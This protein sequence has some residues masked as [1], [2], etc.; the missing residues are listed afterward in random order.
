[1]NPLRVGLVVNPVAGIGGS[2]GL[3]G[4][5][6]EDVQ[7]WA[8]SLGGIPAAPRRATEALEVLR[9]EGVPFTLVTGGGPMGEDVA[10]ASGRAPVEVAVPRRPHTDSTS[11]KDTTQLVAR[12]ASDGV[13]VLLFAGGDGTARD[14]AAA[15]ASS[16][17]KIPFPAI[18]IPGGVKMHS[19]VF[20]RSP[21]A[22]GWMAAEVL[23][24]LHDGL[25]VPLDLAEIVDLDE[26]D[27]RAG[28]MTPRM[29]G[30]MPVP[31]SKTLMQGR[32]VGAGSS[33]RS[34]RAAGFAAEVAALMEE[35]GGMWVMGPGTTVA[36]VAS[37]LGVDNTLLGF[38][39]VI[40]GS[41]EALD[42]NA[43]QLN[44]MAQ[45]QTTHVVLSPVGG[46]GMLLGRGNQQLDQRF[47]ES[48]AARQLVI[49]ATEDKLARLEASSLFLD[50]PTHELNQKLSGYHRVITGRGRFAI[51]RVVAPRG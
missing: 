31:R 10:V 44:R 26:A 36:S 35:R 34:P 27:R 50:A 47:L 38:D 45:R 4:S 12:L 39:V 13:D 40:A 25:P 8:R 43:E 22:A 48:L 21:R 28:I 17:R 30:T 24:R 42:V 23:A 14:V 49:V 51:I 2:V 41:T 16:S 15:L 1:M 33:G 37:T 29:F 11:V 20:A 9:R 7:A 6:G 46:H 19:G 5:D 18:G 32:K 3:K